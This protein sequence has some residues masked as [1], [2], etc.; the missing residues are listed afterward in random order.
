MD[1][2]AVARMLRRIAD[3]LD[4]RNENRF[5]IQAYRVAAQSVRRP[6][7]RP[8]RPRASDTSSNR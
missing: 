7:T 1:N 2:G 5:K 8:S 6:R 3:L 4:A